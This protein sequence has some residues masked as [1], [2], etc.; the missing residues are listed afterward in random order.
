MVILSMCA[1]PPSLKCVEHVFLECFL[2]LHLFL[3]FLTNQLVVVFQSFTRSTYL[4]NVA[5]VDFKFFVL[6]L[7]MVGAIQ[8]LGLSSYF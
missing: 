1:S 5:H 6:F 3:C 8:H 4:D 7:L 2:L